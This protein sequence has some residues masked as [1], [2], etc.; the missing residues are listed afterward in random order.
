MSP[1]LQIEIGHTRQ[2]PGEPD[3]LIQPHKSE[4]LDIGTLIRGYTLDAAY[5]LHMEDKIGSLTVGKK[6]D[7]VVLDKNL[8][9][10]DPY[11]IHR[12]R[13]LLTV[14]DGNIVFEAR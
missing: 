10:V 1:V 11:A 12:T 2:S 3:A 9:D 4:R 14:V 13:V 5:Q 7:L 6:A 8:F